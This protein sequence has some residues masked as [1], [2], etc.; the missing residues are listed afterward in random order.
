MIWTEKTRLIRCSLYPWGQ[1]EGEGFSSNKLLNLASHTV[2]YS[3]FNWPIIAY[4]LTGRYCFCQSVC[5]WQHIWSVGSSSLADSS[6]LHTEAV[7]QCDS[8]HCG[9]YQHGKLGWEWKRKSKQMTR[10]GDWRTTQ[11][12]P[13]LKQLFH[14]WK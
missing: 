6:Y 4:T 14:S 12:A 13:K 8:A 3:P 11:N 1:T 7:H 9:M 5:C 10:H 2:T